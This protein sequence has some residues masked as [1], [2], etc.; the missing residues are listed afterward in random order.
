MKKIF[1]MLIMV[2]CVLA[3]CSK[4]RIVQPVH[5][6]EEEKTNTTELV[7]NNF[8]TE[9][10]AS[11]AQ[12]LASSISDIELKGLIKNMAQEQFDGDYDILV[13]TLHSPGIR[14]TLNVTSLFAASNIP[15]RSGVT[16]VEDLVE[17]IQ[18]RFP[19]LQVSVPVHCEEWDTEN[20]TPLVAFLPYDYDEDTYTEI[21]A[22]DVDGNIH[23]L[24]LDEEP[25]VPVIVVSISER[26]DANGNLIDDA[27]EIYESS[28]VSTKAAPQTPSGLKIF[29]SQSGTIELEWL[30]VEDETAY[31]IYRKTGG[32]GY[33]LIA[34]L[35]T[36]ENCYVDRALQAGKQYSYRVKAINKDGSSAY[37][38]MVATCASDREYDK[39][40]TLTGMYFTKEALKAVEKWASGAPE[41]R[42]RVVG[43]NSSGAVSLF[44]SGLM[45]P[46]KRNYIQDNWWEVPHIISSSWNPINHGTILTFDWREEDW[47]DNVEFTIKPSVEV[48]IDGIWK[49]DL[50]SFSLTFKGDDGG[51]VIG[52]GLVHWWDDLSTTFELTGFKWTIE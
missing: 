9:L 35:D 38:S 51:D 10:I 31:E 6:M 46:E 18:D 11:Y 23:V 27:Y 17:E 25:T 16:N 42:L 24:S 28:N 32:S 2:C 30:D 4:E 8:K 36:N 20:L 3:S 39:P 34:Q 1:I 47:D 41:I 49:V 15:T 44:T 52:S 5:E 48:T 40:L 43:A 37:T 13:K 19:N 33:T 26:V 21:T 14:S 22:Y 7:S 12:L 29:P 50:S 45:E